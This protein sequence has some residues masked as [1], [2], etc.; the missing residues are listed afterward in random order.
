M[1]VAPGRAKRLGLRACPSAAL[2]ATDLGSDTFNGTSALDLRREFRAI[3]KQLALR[4]PGG[5]ELAE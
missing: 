5:Q 4:L 1:D 3:Q 2:L